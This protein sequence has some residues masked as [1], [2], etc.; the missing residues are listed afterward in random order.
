MILAGC[1]RI[2]R[3]LRRS[4]KEN[5]MSN[6]VTSGTKGNAVEFSNRNLCE[7]VDLALADTMLH[8]NSDADVKKI[9]ATHICGCLNRFVID[10]RVSEG[11]WPDMKD[12]WEYLD[13]YESKPEY[14]M[15]AQIGI[16]MF[17]EGYS[18]LRNNYE[19]REV[20]MTD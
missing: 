5:F 14:E 15:T 9:W 16:E 20:D 7:V 12:I 1:Q 19:A 18:N 4:K 3:Q 10:C 8:A 11:E 6:A 17:Y 2:D 13:Q